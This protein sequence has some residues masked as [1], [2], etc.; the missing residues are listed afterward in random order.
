[1]IEAHFLKLRRRDQISAEEERAIRDMFTDVREFPAYRAIVRR[2]QELKES[3][4]LLSG[5][6][7][8][9][10]DLRDGG[11]QI[12][13]LAFAGDFTDLHGFTLKRLDHHIATITP[14]RFAIAPHDRVQATLERHPHLARVYWMMT[15][16][17]GAIHREWTVSLGRRSAKSRMAHLFCEILERLK[18]VRL[19]DNDSYDFPLTQQELGECLGL[20]S[21]HVNRTLQALRKRGLI[22]VENR[23]ATIV[24]LQGLKAL[25]EFDPDYLY[26]ENRPR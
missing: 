3:L 7:A 16:I 18:V 26:L 23:R 19:A 12:S 11:R 1:M 13:E 15:N 4:L 5:W 17:D 20:T 9:T 2:G 10:K 21:V 24:D 22:Q 6:I 25:G 14:C 8:R